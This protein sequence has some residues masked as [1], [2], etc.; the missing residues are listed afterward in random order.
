MKVNKVFSFAFSMLLAA[1]CL[2]TKVLASDDGSG[3]DSLE[4]S[5]VIKGT[6]EQVWA[7]IADF[8]GYANWNE[9]MVRLDGEPELGAYLKG[10]AASGMHLDLQ[11]TSFIPN[12]EICWVDVTWFT[13]LGVGGWRCRSIQELPDGQGVLFVNHFQYTGTFGRALEYVTR[14]FLVQ[15]RQ[16]ENANLKAYIERPHLK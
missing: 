3:L 9:W 7:T 13:N 14:D 15:G 2:S 1:S 11:I 8:E 5:V 12:Q 10:Y 16:Q 6:S 4:Y